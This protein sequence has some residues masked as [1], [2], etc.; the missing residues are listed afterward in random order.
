MFISYIRSRTLSR[1]SVYISIDSTS[2]FKL[3]FLE[4]IHSICAKTVSTRNGEKESILTK[5]VQSSI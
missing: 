2:N 5:I 3:L 1:S 4:V